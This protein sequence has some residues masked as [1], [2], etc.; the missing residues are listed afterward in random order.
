MH[1]FS[2]GSATLQPGDSHHMMKISKDPNRPSAS[3]VSPPRFEISCGLFKPRHCHFYFL[4]SKLS[5]LHH[6]GFKGASVQRGAHGHGPDKIPVSKQS[7]RQVSADGCL[8]YA[9]EGFWPC[10]PS[11]PRHVRSRKRK[12]GFGDYLCINLRLFEMPLEN[13]ASSM[14]PCTVF[15]TMNPPRCR[16]TARRPAPQHTRWRFIR[17]SPASSP[18]PSLATSRIHV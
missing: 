4:N 11:I 3:F 1:T 5:D 2:T 10:G 17:P 8:Q 18:C 7:E 12:L 15:M 16:R 13:S 6:Q 9:S 14:L